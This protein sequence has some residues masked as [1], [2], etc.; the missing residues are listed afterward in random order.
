MNQV[1]DILGNNKKTNY[2]QKYNSNWQE[3][4]SRER[5][6]AY[7]TIEKMAFAIKSNGDKFKQ[8][9]DIQSRFKKHS[10]GN[11]FLIQVR[12]PDTKIFR[13]KAGWN[14]AGI[15]LIKNPKS[16]KILEPS[17]SEK[18]GRVYYN[19]KAVYD[20]SQTNADQQLP[21]INYSNKELLTAFIH[22]CFAQIKVVDKLP[23]DTISSKYDKNDNIL[24]VC[25]GME[26]ELLFQS[27]SQELASIEMRQE[28][29]SSYKEFKG[30]CIS[31]ML[32]KRYGIDVSNYDFNRLPDE[33]RRL[34][35]NIDIRTELDTIR[36]DFEKIDDRITEYFEQKSK[37]QEKSKKVQE[38]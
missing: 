38:R 36:V 20:I 11:C 37:E 21:E 15:E 18:S 26:R 2:K 3:Q 25:R 24:Y 14:K 6:E 29:E 23:D 27:L 16:F 13:D 19:P 12:Q 1:N 4:Q 28:S 31:Y 17:K 34:D 8:Y 7:E 22:N 33:I 5:K 32:C 30:Y 35:T 10:V 9:L